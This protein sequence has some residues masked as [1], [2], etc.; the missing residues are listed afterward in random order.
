M[1]LLLNGTHA[2]SFGAATTVPEGD[3]SA[4]Q[5]LHPRHLHNGQYATASFASQTL[6]H[7][8]SVESPAMPDSHAAAQNGQLLHCKGSTGA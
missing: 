5:K 4:V 7:P 1:S 2:P 8:L 6:E 3:P